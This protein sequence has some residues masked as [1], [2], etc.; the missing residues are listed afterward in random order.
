LEKL[1]IGRLKL[2]I[3]IEKCMQEEEYHIQGVIP[4]VAEGSFYWEVTQIGKI[5]NCKI[6]IEIKIEK[7]MQGEDYHVQGVI[8]DV[9][10]GSF[11]WE[12]THRL[13]DWEII[14][15][16]FEYENNKE[17]VRFLKYAKDSAGKLRNKLYVLQKVDHIDLEYYTQ[18]HTRLINLSKQIRGV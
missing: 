7:C 4:T 12:V 11:Y 10:E 1:K 16:G 14:S 8:P 5:E 13:Q 15:E 3:K 9:A 18:M 2:E 6:E 17:F